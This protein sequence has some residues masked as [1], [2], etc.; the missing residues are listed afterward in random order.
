MPQPA[1]MTFSADGTIDSWSSEAERITGFPASNI[2][3]R[4]FS[5]VVNFATCSLDESDALFRRIVETTSEGIW[6]IN[7]FGKIEY[8]NPRILELLGYSREQMIGQ[9]ILNFVDSSERKEIETLISNTKV[10]QFSVLNRRFIKSDGTILWT[11][12]SSSPITD[13]RGRLV[14]R[15][16]I[17]TDLSERRLAENERDQFFVNSLDMLGIASAD[18]HFLKLNPEFENVLG[19]KLEDL[20]SKPYMEF[21]HADDIPSTLAEMK[22]MAEGIPTSGF[23][24]RYRC[25]NGEY[26][27][28]SWRTSRVKDGRCFFVARDVTEQ[29]LAAQ[30]LRKSAEM[31][32]ALADLG[33]L[34]LQKVDLIHV[35]RTCIELSAKVINFEFSDLAVVLPDHK[36]SQVVATYGWSKEKMDLNSTSE[37]GKGSHCGYT[38]ASGKMVYFEDIESEYRFDTIHLKKLGIQCGISVLVPQQDDNFGVL[39][40]HGR[41]VR[42]IS[43]KEIHFLQS[44]ANVLGSAVER[45][46]LESRLRTSDRL[47]S[48]GALA[49][50]VAHE[51]NNPM[52][53]VITNLDLMASLLSSSTSNTV[54]VSQMLEMIS[55]AQHG[56]ERVRMVVKDLKTFSSSSDDKLEPLRLEKIIDFSVRMAMNQIRYRAKLTTQYD[57]APAVMINENRLGQVILNILINA[58]QALPEGLLEENEIHVRLGTDPTGNAIIE[59]NDTGVGIPESVLPRIF[60]PF[61]TTKPVGMGTGLGLSICRNIITKLNGELT[62]ESRV[63]IGTKVRIILPPAIDQT[64]TARSKVDLAIPLHAMVQRKL[65]I[66]DDESLLVETLGRALSSD[67]IVSTTTSPAEALRLIDKDQEAFDVILCDLMMPEMTGMDFYEQLKKRY[68]GSESRIVFMTGGT[69]TSQAQQFLNEVP[70]VRLE[71]PFNLKEIRAL[72]QQPLTTLWKESDAKIG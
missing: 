8:V 57:P 45:R 6:T 52:S 70:N 14:G 53:F 50:G 24:N 16:A 19:W 67:H 44:M 58:V 66:I 10:G 40:L 2:V 60:D 33:S 7:L 9:S 27:W 51:I 62:V 5:E 46:Q 59:V 12:I 65:L 29:K 48:V 56:A 71:K 72:L 13:H 38:L 49:A 37:I 15:L 30:R 54:D 25:R 63:G 47:A 32:S 42:R 34:A 26:R 18:G 23:E 4:H 21:V 64:M 35:Y 39:S 20:L 22:K 31:Q 68:P 3:G 55:Q 1:H 17:V 36:T 69:F 61:F 43:L 41:N 28:L 11:R